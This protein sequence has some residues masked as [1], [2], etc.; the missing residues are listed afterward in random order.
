M[1]C[2][3]QGLKYFIHIPLQKTFAN[4][5]VTKH[6]YAELLLRGFL[7]LNVY[8]QQPAVHRLQGLIDPCG[9]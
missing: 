7:N 6:K 5:W 1:V 3:P 4:P 8:V 9:N 2:S